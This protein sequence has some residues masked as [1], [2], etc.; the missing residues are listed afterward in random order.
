MD[1]WVVSNFFFCGNSL[2][3]CIFGGPPLSFISLTRSLIS[4]TPANCIPGTEP[5]SEE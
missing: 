5:G 2:D 4:L 1:F 3:N